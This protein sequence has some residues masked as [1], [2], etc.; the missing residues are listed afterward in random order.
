MSGVKVPRRADVVIAGSYPMDTISA[1]R[2][3]GR[4]IDLVP[5]EER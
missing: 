4:V 5:A 2:P 1:A 3:G